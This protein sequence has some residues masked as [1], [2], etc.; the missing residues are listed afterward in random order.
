M[1][2][3]TK[4]VRDALVTLMRL[5]ARSQAI[6]EA[7]QEIYIECSKAKRNDPRVSQIILA[8][9]ATKINMAND[10][11]AECE[12]SAFERKLDLN[13]FVHASV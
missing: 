9:V 5:P 2:A 4:A 13:A 7:I 10:D 1:N 11:I 12:I 6:E 8:N 3:E